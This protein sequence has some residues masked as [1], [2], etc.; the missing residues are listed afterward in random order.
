M[1]GIAKTKGWI[2]LYKPQCQA[3]VAPQSPDA[4]N[5]ER[6]ARIPSAEMSCLSLLISERFTVPG[7]RQRVALPRI[8]ISGDSTKL[9]W[10]RANQQHDHT[11]V[12]TDRDFR[13]PSSRENAI[14][15]LRSNP[16]V[17][18]YTQC[19]GSRGDGI[20]FRLLA[21]CP[22]HFPAAALRLPVFD[23]ELSKLDS[24]YFLAAI[25]ERTDA[26][27]LRDNARH[28]GCQTRGVKSTLQAAPWPPATLGLSCRF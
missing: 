7:P 24:S 19:I 28:N 8:A 22:V 21:K 17:F 13:G 10:P 14:L 16:G 18:P 15:L 11:A 5:R 25:E 12:D 9:Q 4:H 20:H 26:G 23:S 2:E 6:P 27:N 3:R 1:P